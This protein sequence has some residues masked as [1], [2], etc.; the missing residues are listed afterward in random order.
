MEIKK[1]K[2]DFIIKMVLATFIGS[3]LLYGVVLVFSLAIKKPITLGESLSYFGA[4][5]TAV[6]TI[7][8]V[9]W[10]IQKN[11]DKID[12]EQENERNNIYNY[13]EYFLRKNLKK[14]GNESNK[15][16]FEQMSLEV[17]A[18]KI[19]GFLKYDCLFY[20]AD[21]SFLIQNASTILSLKNGEKLFDLFNDINDINFKVANEGIELNL[22]KFL[23]DLK[24]IDFDDNKEAQDWIS[25]L[26][27]EIGSLFYLITDKEE[28]AYKTKV[29][30]LNLLNELKL[31]GLLKLLYIDIIGEFKNRKN[32]TVMEIYLKNLDFINEF[33]HSKTIIINHKKTEQ[34]LEEM[35]FY[36]GTERDFI[37][38]I[39]N[40]LQEIKVKFD[41]IIEIIEII[42]LDKQQ[43]S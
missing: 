29:E 27:G 19:H 28:T 3:G 5:L 21:T 32:Y 9:M 18:R 35:F 42:E 20:S 6:V 15:L 2:Y 43:D 12:S 22:V 39:K 41:E 33:Q 24:Q 40:Q 11:N 23:T 30:N 26:V 36:I 10:Q 31:G 1:D 13:L 4:V 14:Y 25:F 7:F 17:L 38:A 34:L 8:G 16:D 37:N